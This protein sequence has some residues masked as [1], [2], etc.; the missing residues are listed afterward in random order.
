MV[1]F[2]SGNWDGEWIE[3]ARRKGDDRWE[4][5]KALTYKKELRWEKALTYKKEL[6][7]QYIEW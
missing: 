1:S 3:K 5:E 6:R 2:T 7:W 4:V